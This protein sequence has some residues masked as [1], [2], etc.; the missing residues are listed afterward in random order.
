MGASPNP[1]GPKSG[2]V[3]ATPRTSDQS[4]G[5]QSKR[6]QDGLKALELENEFKAKHFGV[7]GVLAW[8]L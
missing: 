3:A 5:G 4:S 6:K 1:S 8:I 2:L 7:M